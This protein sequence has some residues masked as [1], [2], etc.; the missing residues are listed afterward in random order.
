MLQG[1]CKN[2]CLV[3]QLRLHISVTPASGATYKLEAL[4]YVHA[5]AIA[6]VGIGCVHYT[7]LCYLLPPSISLILMH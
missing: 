3:Q 1:A 6:S 2:Y 5:A 7:L 4:P